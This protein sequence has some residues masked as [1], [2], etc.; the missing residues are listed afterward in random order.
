MKR[1]N[2]L[3]AIVALTAGA[4]GYLFALNRDALKLDQYTPNLPGGDFTLQSING[5]VK[6]SDFKGKLVLVYFGYTYC[7]DICPTALSLT[8][9]ALKQLD[10]QQRAQ[11][12]SLFISVDPGRDDIARL[13]EYVHFFHPSMIGLTGSKAEIDDVSR[14]YGAYY[15]IM[16]NGSAT[17]YPV[18]HSSQTV[19][20]GK[21]GTIK[22]IIR[23]GT[24]PAEM[25]KIIS[26]Y[27]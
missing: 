13:D 16:D 7:P 21:D 10:E 4:A 8:G 15:K 3:F 24:A 22:S 18:D 19:V 5:P 14:R 25:V 20:V 17:D 11:V 1:R 2:L 6:L 23:H 9:A 26:A 12:Q 27:L